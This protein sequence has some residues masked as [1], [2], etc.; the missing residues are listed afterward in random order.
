MVSRRVVGYKTSR[1][2]NTFNRNQ[3]IQEGNVYYRFVIYMAFIISMR[4]ALL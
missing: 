2:F 3:T 1:K 4:Y